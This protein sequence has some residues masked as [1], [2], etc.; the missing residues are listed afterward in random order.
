MFSDEALIFCKNGVKRMKCL[1]MFRVAKFW[2]KIGSVGFPEANLYFFWP[3]LH[4]KDNLNFSIQFPLKFLQKNM[5]KIQ[6]QNAFFY[7]CILSSDDD[8]ARRVN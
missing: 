5:M 2:G 7:L 1:K 6:W 8:N 4:E 3:T